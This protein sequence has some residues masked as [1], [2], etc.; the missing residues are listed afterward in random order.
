M[1]RPKNKAYDPAKHHDHQE[2]HKLHPRDH[3]AIAQIEASMVAMQ[4]AKTHILLRAAS[5]DWNYP[6]GKALSFAPNYETGDVTVT[7]VNV[8]SAKSTDKGEENATE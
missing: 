6:N 5:V 3:V 8:K 7:M 1:A 4:E 2:T